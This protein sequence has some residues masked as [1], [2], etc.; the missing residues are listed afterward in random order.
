VDKYAAKAATGSTWS[1]GERLASP[2]S[3]RS[4]NLTRFALLSVLRSLVV[5]DGNF[6]ANLK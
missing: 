6:R 1:A 3:G 5:P 4:R 2:P